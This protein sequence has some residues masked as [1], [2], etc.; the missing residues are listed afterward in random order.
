VQVNVRRH[1]RASRLK[2]NFNLPL[3]GVL[4]RN[5]ALARIY[6]YDSPQEMIDSVTNIARQLYI[7]PQERNE[8]TRLLITLGA[9]E[10]YELE[11]LR[12]DGTIIWTST[13]AR[14]VRDN[15]GNLLYYEGFLQDITKR[16]Q[17]ELELMES[18]ARYRDLFDSPSLHWEEDLPGSK[19]LDKLRQNG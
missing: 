6:G 17:A 8:F 3:D 18:Q 7:E 2:P 14:V 5:P 16:K 15:L 4:Q 9:V 1:L 19:H 11:N 13:S 12:K 10:N